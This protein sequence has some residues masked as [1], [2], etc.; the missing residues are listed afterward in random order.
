MT[1]IIDQCLPDELQNHCTHLPSF[2]LQRIA[3]AQ[4]RLLSA[5]YWHTDPSWNMHDR[6]ST[7]DFIFIPIRGAIKVTDKNDTYIIEAGQCMFM[8]EGMQRNISYAPGHQYIE[9]I[10]IHAHIH[11]ALGLPLLHSLNKTSYPFPIEQ[12]AD[13]K[14]LISL[15]NQD[16]ACGQAY[17]KSLIRQLLSSWVLQGERLSKRDEFDARI[18]KALNIIHEYYASDLSVENIAQDVNL[19]I[20]QF[21]KLFK[22]HV[23]ET[24]KLYIAHYRLRQAAQV[25]RDTHDSIKSI[26][27]SHGFADEH[28]FHNSFKKLYQCTPQQFRLR[29]PLEA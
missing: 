3:Q 17:G 14:N 16:A 21:R 23:H 24:P 25:L 10:A 13:Y 7:D 11:S 12:L 20:V 8:S 4:I 19:G 2:D 27:L 18:H 5:I 26:A 6:L 15:F 29:I 22:R 9:V 28:Y 1:Q